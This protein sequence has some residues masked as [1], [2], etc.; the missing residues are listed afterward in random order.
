MPGAVWDEDFIVEA[1]GVIG[2]VRLCV[3]AC[4]AQD[5]LVF[6]C[7]HTA[8]PDLLFS[9]KQS[10]LLELCKSHQHFVI[11]VH[12]QCEEDKHWQKRQTACLDSMPL[13]CFVTSD[14]HV[15]AEAFSR[16]K[17]SKEAGQ[18]IDW[19]HSLKHGPVHAIYSAV[20]HKA[21]YSHNDLT[22]DLD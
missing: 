16:L 7:V 19:I 17:A 8:V 4:W 1:L 3:Y 14:A 13:F 21:S 6:I 15:N 18:M 20:L 22:E 10:S 11:N 2:C 5:V 12:R 9:N